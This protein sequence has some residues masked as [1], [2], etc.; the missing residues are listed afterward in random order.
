MRVLTNLLS[1]EVQCLIRKTKIEGVQNK[2][3]R[4]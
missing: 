1:I 3:K 2:C 4:K